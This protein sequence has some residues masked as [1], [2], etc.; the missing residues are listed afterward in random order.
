MLDSF[1]IASDIRTDILKCIGEK[2]LHELARIAEAAGVSEASVK[3][4][5]ALAL[6]CGTPDA[7]AAEL[8][9]LGCPE[10]PLVQLLTVVQPLI[11]AGFSDMLAIDFSVVN[12]MRYYNGIIFKGFVDGV[13]TGVLSGGRYDALIQKMGRRAGAIGFAV[14]LDQLERLEESGEQY[15]VDVVL[16]YDADMSVA[17]VHEAVRSFTGAGLRVTAQRTLPEKLR[18]RQLIRLRESGVETN[19]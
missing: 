19:A 8:R 3:A 5:S 12:D 4:L 18:Y 7:V 1:G 14:Y 9:S 17:A 10:E 15:D 2:N 6:M 13:P 11:D 16:L